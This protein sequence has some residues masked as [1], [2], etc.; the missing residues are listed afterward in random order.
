MK[1][2]CKVIKAYKSA[3]PEPMIIKSGA[4]LKIGKRDDKWEGWIWC[5]N[6][7]GQSR[8]VPEN[9]LRIEGDNAIALCD[10]D[11]TELTVDVDDDLTVLK[12]ESGWAWCRKMD[13]LEGWVPL[14]NVEVN[15][16]I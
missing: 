13:G 16:E 14:E 7:N 12:K 15:Q 8:W 1:L 11:A 10:Y 5:T 4:E 6:Y 3:Y 9:Y 2:N